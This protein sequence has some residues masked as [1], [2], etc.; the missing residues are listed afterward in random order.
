[1][2]IR[3]GNGAGSFTTKPDV[4]VG[5]NPVSVA[6]ADFNGDGKLDFAVDIGSSNIVSI[7]L[8]DGAGGFSA[9]PNATVGSLPSGLVAGDFN[10]DGKPDLVATNWRDNTF[11]LLLNTF[12][13]PVPPAPP[14]RVIIAALV[15]RK[16][17]KNRL[18][19]VRVTFADTGALKSEVRSPF[20]KPAFRRIVASAFDSDG[21]G[22]ADSVRL[23]AKRGKRTLTRLITV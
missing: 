7:R 21:D 17:R 6:V 16:V 8:G 13:G 10:G 23:T 11:T 1:V 15:T 2:S 22:L 18:L 14:A 9:E 20:Q 3:L 5:L 4:A 19:F 12:P